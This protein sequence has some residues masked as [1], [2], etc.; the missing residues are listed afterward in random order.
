MNPL[1]DALR[2]TL[3]GAAGR[4]PQAPV[5]LSGAVEARYRRR[6]NR[7]RAALAAAAVVALVGGATF[8]LKGGTPRAM[9]AT[10]PTADATAALPD[11]VDK[12]W[13]QAV[14]D[15]PARLPNGRAFHPIRLLDDHT[16]LVTVDAGFE[17]ADV[18]YAYDLE[19]RD[20]RK[21]ADVPTP[22]GTIAFASGFAAGEGRVAWWTVKEGGQGMIWSAPLSG[23]EATVVARRKVDDGGFDGLAVTDGKIV[24]SAQDGGVFTVPLGGGTVEAVEGGADM[25]LLSWPWIGTVGYGGPSD[26]PRFGTIRNVETGETDTALTRAGEQNISCGLV[27]CM[28]ENGAGERFHRMRD[29]SREQPAPCLLSAAS[30][31]GRF[32]TGPVKGAHGRPLG[33]VLHDLTTGRSADLGIRPKGKEMFL[34]VPIGTQVTLPLDKQL[35][36]V[37]LTKI[38]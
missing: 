24:F 31:P 34:P 14:R 36:L 37:D 12:V 28:G 26:E 19:S 10:P 2:R 17:K 23:G 21:I 29:G 1:E 6:R 30:T 35:R 20:L 33:M 27:F 16:L 9:P 5:T 25:H 8:A 32:C 4:A 13:P 38:P 3:T 22:K 18:V 15:I 11:P 7:T